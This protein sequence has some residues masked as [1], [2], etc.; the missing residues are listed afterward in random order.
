MM[1]SPSTPRPDKETRRLTSQYSSS[2][3]FE[4]VLPKTGPLTKESPSSTSLEAPVQPAPVA[5]APS[6]DIHN[7][8]SQLLGAG[9]IGGP[10]SAAAIPGLEVAPAANNA[11]TPKV[12]KERGPEVAKVEEKAKAVAKPVEPLE[13]VKPVVLR[14]HDRTLKR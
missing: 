3:S 6:V 12:K 14:S 7:L 5:A 9:L 2:P 10:G 1:P 4:G 11:S 13:V 8:W